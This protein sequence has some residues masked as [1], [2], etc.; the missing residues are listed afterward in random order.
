MRYVKRLRGRFRS[1]TMEKWK[2]I[3][4]FP[5]YM[6]SNFG[7]VYSKKSGLIMK[8]G[9]DNKG[10]LR[11]SFYENGR[12]NTRK[13]HRLV[14]ETFIDNPDNLPQVNH[15]NEI[16]TDNRVENLEWCS[17]SYNRYYG[18][19]TERTQ[20]ANMNCK[21]TSVPVRCV[22]TGEIYPSIREAS[23]DTG[24]KNIFWC[25]IGKR[26]TSNGLHWEYATNMRR[27]DNRKVVAC[28]M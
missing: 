20:K 14:A 28:G 5:N 26:Q 10:Y 8:P 18:T 27:A 4:G 17:N 2:D 6:I 22:E 12:S 13:V 1:G 23:R 19:A 3:T 9:K 16:K 7:R 21:S 24:A 11:V 25:C 15:K